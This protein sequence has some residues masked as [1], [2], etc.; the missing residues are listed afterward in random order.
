MRQCDSISAKSSQFAASDAL[1]AIVRLL[2]RQAARE[3]VVQASALPGR[4]K[5]SQPDDQR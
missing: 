4:Q 2:A 5:Q 3:F 1:I